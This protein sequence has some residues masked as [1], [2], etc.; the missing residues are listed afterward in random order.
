M[1]MTGAAFEVSSANRY[2]LPVRAPGSD[3][4]I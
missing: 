1:S 2:Y 3:L 4:M